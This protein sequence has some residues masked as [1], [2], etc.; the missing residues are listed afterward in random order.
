VKLLIGGAKLDVEHKAY[1]V[2]IDIDATPARFDKVP[3]ARDATIR[4]DSARPETISYMQRNGYPGTDSV[5]K[6]KGS[7]EDG[8]AALRGFE[9]IVIPP[10]CRHAE[11]EAR[12]WSYKVDRLSGDV[13]PE[14]VDR[15]NH[16][17]DAVRYALEPIIRRSNMGLFEWMREQAALVNRAA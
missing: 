11:D 5:V 6:W 1:G 4:A 8:V 12:L 15:H 17:F 10:R 2:G 9:Q 14:L 16:I 3:D 7:I 13:L